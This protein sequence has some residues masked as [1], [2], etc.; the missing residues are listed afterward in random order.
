MSKMLLW[1]GLFLLLNVQLGSSVNFPGNT[2]GSGGGTPEPPVSR[3]TDPPVTPP[4]FI[5]ASD[6]L[7]TPPTNPPVTPP[8][9]RQVD[10]VDP[11]FCAG[12]TDGLYVNLVNSSK[13]YICAAEITYALRCADGLEFQAVCNCCN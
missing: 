11:N 5:P 12:K 10:D 1:A 9:V 2:C 13:F 4:T 7:V 8:I 3:P 6:P